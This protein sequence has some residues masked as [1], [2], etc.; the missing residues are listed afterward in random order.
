M[1]RVSAMDNILQAR[2]SCKPL[3]R[4]S[5]CEACQDEGREEL[6]G[7]FMHAVNHCRTS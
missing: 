7:H 6:M 4:R 3:Q 2:F 1:G 5:R